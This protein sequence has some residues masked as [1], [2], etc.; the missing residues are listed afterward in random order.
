[1]RTNRHPGRCC[2]CG[3]PVPVGAGTLAERPDRW[4]H[5]CSADLCRQLVYGLEPPEDPR[6]LRADGTIPLPHHGPDTPLLEAIATWDQPAGLWRISPLAGDFTLVLDLC[7]R[8]GVTVDKGVTLDPRLHA[9]AQTIEA[10]ARASRTCNGRR[11]QV[12][13]SGWLASHTHGLLADVPGLGKTKQSLDALSDD[14]GVLV[15]TPAVAKGV[16]IREIRKW[17]SD[18]FD[19][20]VVCEGWGS[21]Q[22][23]KSTRECVIVNYD[24]IP[25]QASELRAA[26]KTIDLV[27]QERAEYLEVCGWSD[28]A[29]RKWWALSSALAKAWRALYRLRNQGAGTVAGRLLVTVRKILKRTPTIG[30]PRSGV[31]VT[32]IFDE[33]H[34][35]KSNKALQTKRCR[36]ISRYSTRCYGLTGTPVENQPLELWGVLTS[37]GCKPPQW[38][39]VPQKGGWFRFL[40]AFGACR[41]PHGGF[42]FEKDD[43]GAIIVKPGTTELLRRV[44]LR[45]TAEDVGEDLPPVTFSEYPV[46]LTSELIAKLDDVEPEA[47]KFLERG[48]I[49]DILAYSRVR[50]A[51]ASSRIA[52]MIEIV[53]SYEEQGVPLFVVSAHRAPIERLAKRKGWRAITGSVSAS[54]RT[55][56][57][58]WFQSGGGV[59]IAGTIASMGVAITLTR[60]AHVLFVDQ[61][62][63]PGANEQARKRVDRIG[64]TA[65]GIH[66]TIMYSDHPLEIRVAEMLTQKGLLAS[67]VLTS[68][69]DPRKMFS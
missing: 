66:V 47:L 65:K 63:N 39:D 1:M 55:E 61:A 43:G 53:K 3:T 22:W 36:I 59:G 33:V 50:K 21:F 69:Y 4:D 51:L 27:E 38:T 30:K 13:G 9:D 28:G 48:E 60:A 35:L 7:E 24:L 62:L 54:K 58:D 5:V 52:A 40:D 11:Y 42:E 26:V 8:M 45:R 44:M 19:S 68:H 23:P 25:P 2:E 29:D 37:I 15:V 34:K 57:V 56:A 10:V 18:R 17:R 32:T 6:V 31:P 12:V 16:W 41:L 14:A 20:V 67:R 49:P 64:Q 46:D